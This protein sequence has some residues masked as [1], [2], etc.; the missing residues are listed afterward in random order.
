MQRTMRTTSQVA[1]ICLITGSPLFGQ[2]AE[3]NVTLQ[4]GWNSVFMRVDPEPSGAN[5]IFSGLP[6]ESVWM[7]V[8]D[9]LIAGPPD[10][11]DP[12]APDCLPARG[13]NWRS[14]L[15]PGNP[16]SIVNT[17][18]VI[19]G[20][21][22][23]LIKATA[24]TTLTLFGIPSHARTRWRVGFNLAG[25]HV[26]GDPQATPTFA[27][28]LAPSSAHIDTRIFDVL[29]DGSLTEVS[30][31]AQTR[32][33]PDKAFWVSS[34]QDTEYDGPLFI[35]PASL[36]GMDFA[37]SLLEHT[38]RVE[39]LAASTRDVTFTYTSSAAVPPVPGLPTLAGDVPLLWMNYGGGGHVGEVYQW[40]EL[41][42]ETWPLPATGV[43]GAARAVRMAV[44]R[45]GLS[46]AVLQPD[47]SG[48]Q[49]QGL[50]E[51]TDGAGYRRFLPVATQVGS[52]AGLWIGHI[53]ADQVSWVTAPL[54]GDPDATTP[55]NT[56]AEFSF[57]ILIHRDD[58][59]QYKCLTEVTLMWEPGD[60]AS[61]TP[62]RY[63]LVTPEVDPAVLAGLE[64]GSLR[65][66]EP[67]APRFS[68][69][70]FSFDGDLPLNGTL[71]TELQGATTIPGEHRLNP[72]K[73]KYHPD[74]DG[75]TAGGEPTAAELYE[76]TRT[77]TLTFESDP[78][79]GLV[80]P[81]WGHS[82]LGGTYAETVEGLHRDSI[83]VAG[84]FELTRVS[85]IATLNGE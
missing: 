29:D 66:G 23:Y 69:A 10:C 71:E 19:R 68:T 11:P 79:P 53:I 28:Y 80:R 45:A 21:R 46:E 55:R 33:T 44:N 83:N 7:P 56:P 6:I 61:S 8:E 59:G 20:G 5:A 17:L 77:F 73:H 75:L 49:Y 30:D 26:V 43:P 35:D 32:I 62:G 12:N 81:G 65:D 82:F 58:S 39:N 15:P 60:V 34:S 84:R 47:G 25:F 64:S 63:V 70:A 36:R 41:Q 13:E 78:A 37:Q 4:E 14:W 85:A 18:G 52:R 76:I 67:Y 48:A 27:E 16:A 54:S 24:Q 74:H 3:Q 38:V 57:P 9:Q 50:L 51:I 40:L 1:V 72:F 42:S 22:V 2:W 31:P